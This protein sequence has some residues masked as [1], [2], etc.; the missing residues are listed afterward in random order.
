M[1]I[2]KKT[3]LGVI[4]SAALVACGGGGGSTNSSDSNQNPT[5]TPFTPKKL[6]EWERIRLC[7]VT[8][9]TVGWMHIV[10]MVTISPITNC[11]FPAH[12]N[13]ISASLVSKETANWTYGSMKVGFI[14]DVPAQNILSTDIKIGRAHV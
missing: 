4:L 3:A 6:S 5:E 7:P 11:R 10:H 1:D 2:K 8:H 12:W 14:L 13:K 9:E